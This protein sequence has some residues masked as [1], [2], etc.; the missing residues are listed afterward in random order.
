MLIQHPLSINKNTITKYKKI[1]LI[2]KIL[3]IVFYKALNFLNF[4]ISLNH[5]SIKKIIFYIN[6]FKTMY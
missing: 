1:L 5:I 2:A 6:S 4:Y 3:F